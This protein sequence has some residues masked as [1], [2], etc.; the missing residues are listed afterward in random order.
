MS[1]QDEHSTRLEIQGSLFPLIQ[2]VTHKFAGSHVFQGDTRETSIV[3]PP[4]SNESNDQFGTAS[5]PTEPLK[6]ML[7]LN[8]R[9]FVNR[10]A[11]FLHSHFEVK[12]ISMGNEQNPVGN[13]IAFCVFSVFGIDPRATQE[14]IAR[15]GFLEL[16][17]IVAPVAQKYHAQMAQ[18][19]GSYVSNKALPSSLDPDTLANMAQRKKLTMEDSALP[20]QDGH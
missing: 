7:D 11:N 12:A 1:N 18:I 3:N 5:D 17:N 8:I 6:D 20:M 9:I 13:E 10:N 14:Q 15:F 4:D 16:P 19:L 2:T